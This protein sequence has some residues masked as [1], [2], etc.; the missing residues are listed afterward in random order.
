MT[1][2]GIKQL[3]HISAIIIPL[4]DGTHPTG[5]A[6]HPFDLSVKNPEDKDYIETVLGVLKQFAALQGYPMH[7]KIGD[8]SAKLDKDTQQVGEYTIPDF[9]VLQAALQRMRGVHDGQGREM[10]EVLAQIAYE[11]V[12]PE[13][14]VAAREKFRTA[15]GE[16]TEVLNKQ[17]EDGVNASRR[18]Q[19]SLGVDNNKIEKPVVPQP[20]TPVSTSSTTMSTKEGGN[21][22]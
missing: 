7:V 12:T 10:L 22:S 16:K 13:E 1:P 9:S 6:H 20:V 19:L 4:L 21:K 17:T 11:K 2:E 3:H 14:L 8:M 18:G 5:S 15:R